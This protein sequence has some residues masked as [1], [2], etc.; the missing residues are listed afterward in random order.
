MG[1]HL[2]YLEAFFALAHHLNF[3]RAAEGLNISQPSL[4]RQIATLEDSLKIQ[5][6]L[7]NKHQVSLTREG[8][9]FLERINPIYESLCD[10]FSKLRQEA[11]ELS[12]E[13]TI[14][15]Y[16]EIG[17]SY[18]FEKIL[19]FVK[20]H[21]HVRFTMQ[22]LSGQEII[23]GVSEGT[24]NFGILAKPNADLDLRCN[25]LMDETVILV[26]NSDNPNHAPPETLPI[27]AYRDRDPILAAF[28]RKNKA[29]YTPQKIEYYCRVNSH[30]SMVQAL[31]SQ[32]HLY[33][34]VPELAVEEELSKGQ[35]KQ[36]SGLIAYEGLYLIEAPRSHNSRLHLELK[37]FLL[38][39]K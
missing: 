28:F 15:C 26:T 16:R 21:S 7:R 22:Y 32:S 38:S 9:F 5:L 1:K 34:V 4:S 27:V 19:E 6:F 31:R 20:D 23:Q 18:Y 14:G 3:T 33:A 35:L 30:S 11:T 25:K 17:Q 8:K 2:N 39:L 12:G 36:V 10:E 24:I 37:D 13:V 29:N